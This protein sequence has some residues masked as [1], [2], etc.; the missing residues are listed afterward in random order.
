MKSFMP[1]FALAVMVP[2]IEI[3]VIAVTIL[4]TAPIGIL[5]MEIIPVIRMFLVPCLPLRRIPVVRPD[6]IS[7]RVSVI[8][9]PPIFRA[10]K[11]IQDSIREPIT[12]VKDPRGISPNPR[13]RDGMKGR[14]GI[15]LSI[16]GYRHGAQ[17]ASSQ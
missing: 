1:T 7:R 5:A 15:D 17:G 13:C 10:E 4:V 16:S 8:R 11:V 9:G 3:F 6:N 12:V 2:V 14:R